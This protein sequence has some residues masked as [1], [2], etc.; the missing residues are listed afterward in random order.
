MS[1]MVAEQRGRDTPWCGSR[2]H[3][4]ERI[5]EQV[6]DPWES[7]DQTLQSTVEQILDAPV[8]EMVGQLVKLPKTLSQ[9]LQ[10]MEVPLLQSINKV[11]D[12]PVVVQRKVHVNQNVQKTIEDIQLQYTD[13]V[14][15]VPVVLVV[16]I[17]Q[18]E[19]VAE[20]VEIPRLWIVE[21][22]DETP[23][24]DAGT[25]KNPVAKVKGLITRVITRLQTPTDLK[26]FDMVTAV[27]WLA[28]QEH[29]AAL[30]QLGSHISAIMKFSAGPDDDPFVKVKD[31]IMDFSRLQEEA[32]SEAYCDEET[33]MAA[34]KED[35][36]DDTAKH[37]STLET[38]EPSSTESVNEGH[39]DKICDQF[40]DVVLDAYL[41]CD[42]KCKVASET[43]VKDIMFMV[44]GEVT[45]AGKLH[46]ETVMKFGA[47]VGEGK[48]E[49]LETHGETHSCRVE[50]AVSTSSVSDSEVAEFQVHLGT[51]F[52]QQMSMGM[53]RYDELKIL[54]TDQEDLDLDLDGNPTVENTQVTDLSEHE[55]DVRSKRQQHEQQ[56]HSNQQQSTQQA[57]QQQTGEKERERGERE[58]R[59]KGRRA[60]KERDKEVKKDVTGWTVVTRSKKQRKRTIQIFVKVN[61]SRT[62]PLDVSPDDKVDDVIRQIQSEEDM[63]VTMHGRVLKRSKKLKSCEVTDGCVLQVMSRMRGGGKHKGK[64]SKAEK[65]QTASGKTLEPKFVEKVRSDKVPAIRECDKDATVTRQESMS[66][67][68]QETHE[69]NEDNMIT[70]WM[71]TA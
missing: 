66:D 36:E 59:E 9:T 69:R 47:T 3:I 8:P 46:H 71:K 18:V 34:E 65:K 26:G 28:E 61:E 1:V 56:H 5:D 60:E 68:S 64:K 57:M 38:A 41:T 22:I 12:A 43:G 31:L 20:T 11:V 35:L 70:C 42:T 17:P 14:V 16:Q 62:F 54:T 2:E 29:S 30:A 39:P 45:V 40:S 50:A 49:N 10:T 23:K 13:G 4:S 58:E 15:D 33:S 44:T 48:K 25:G 55:H 67:V 24:F 37:S 27:R 7:Q 19:V 21:K 52:A 53:R 51:F 63:Y 6:V 32:S